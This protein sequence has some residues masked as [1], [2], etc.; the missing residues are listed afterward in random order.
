M[1]P[2]LG[3]ADLKRSA[4][5][6]ESM[7][8]ESIRMSRSL[9]ADLSPSILHEGGLVAGLEW[10]ARS[11]RDKHGL[12]VD[13]TM[14]KIGEPP[15]DV[16]IMVFESVRELLFNTVKHAGVTRAR[17]SLSRNGHTGLT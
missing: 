12:T 6:I 7:I 15:E 9:S 11:M 14:Q 10:L 2:Q 3:D 8:G 17:L 1:G 13:V 5:E 16:K 4:E